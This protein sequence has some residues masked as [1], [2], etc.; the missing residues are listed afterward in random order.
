MPLKASMPAKAATVVKG[1]IAL[2]MIASPC[3]LRK[4][5]ACEG[6][7]ML[8]CGYAG[9]LFTIVRVARF[10]LTTGTVNRVIAAP[11]APNHAHRQVLLVECTCLT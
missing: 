3:S 2:F 8:P 4:R 10:V 9:A 5:A 11:T 7:C 1:K 6:L